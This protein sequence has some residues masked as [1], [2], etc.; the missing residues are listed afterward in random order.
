[1]S[2]EMVKITM[3]LQCKSI[4][5]LGIHHCNLYTDSVPWHKIHNSVQDQLEVRSK[6]MNIQILHS[7]PVN[8]CKLIHTSSCCADSVGVCL[9]ALGHDFVPASTKI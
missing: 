8:S 2:K 4:P 1:M 5:Y 3:V 6:L 9:L 7:R